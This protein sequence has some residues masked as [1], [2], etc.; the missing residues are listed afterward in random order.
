MK[1]SIDIRLSGRLRRSWL[2]EPPAAAGGAVWGALFSS[3]IL[4]LSELP[5]VRPDFTLPPSAVAAAPRGDAWPCAVSR[6]RL[7]SR[8]QRV[9]LDDRRARRFAAIPRRRSGSDRPALVSPTRRRISAADRGH[10]RQ[11]QHRG[12]AHRFRDV[13]Q[14]LAQRVGAAPGPARAPTARSRRCTRWRRRRS[15][16]RP[17]P[18]LRARSRPSACGS[19][20][21]LS[22][23][24]AGQPARAPTPGRPA[25]RGTAPPSPRRG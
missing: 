6:S 7:R 17:P 18:R 25:R 3:T 4:L 2:A 5:A 23:G 1:S 21:A 10:D 11:Q 12:D 16:T 15:G 13:E 24:D 9:G 14:H 19:P 20:R 22:R 8:P